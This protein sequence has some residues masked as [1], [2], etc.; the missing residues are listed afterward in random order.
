MSIVSLIANVK[1]LP[2]GNKD[3]LPYRIILVEEISGTCFIQIFKHEFHRDGFKQRTSSRIAY[4]RALTVVP[5]K[6]S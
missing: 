2:K 1:E 3:D 6:F 4:T 5:R